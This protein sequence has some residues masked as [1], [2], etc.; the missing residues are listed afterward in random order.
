M[1]RRPPSSHVESNCSN[2]L[3]DTE[4]RASAALI[5]HQPRPSNTP[6]TERVIII[7]IIIII[8]TWHE[9]DI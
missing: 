6:N 2:D 4:D 7:I 9:Y 1:I 8:I 5:A 3:D